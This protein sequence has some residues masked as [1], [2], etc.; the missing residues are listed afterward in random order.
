MLGHTDL[1]IHIDTRVLTINH[2]SDTVVSLNVQSIDLTPE[3][4]IL[5]TTSIETTMR[6]KRKK[7]K[8]TEKTI[9]KAVI[10]QCMSVKNTRMDNMW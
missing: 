8:R 4:P 1:R 2:Q 9:A 7:K 10:I 5:M 3:D 6:K